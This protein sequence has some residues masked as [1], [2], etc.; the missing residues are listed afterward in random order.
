MTLRREAG[1][2]ASSRPKDLSRL[3]RFSPPFLCDLCVKSFDLCK[4]ATLLPLQSSLNQTMRLIRRQK[5]LRRVIHPK[6]RQ[7]HQIKMF[8]GQ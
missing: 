7:I 1:A 3:L 5:N 8:I 2:F 6:R 4:R